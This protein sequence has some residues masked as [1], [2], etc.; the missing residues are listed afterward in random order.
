MG[1]EMSLEMSN[2]TFARSKNG[3]D[4]LKSNLIH[5]IDEVQKNLKGEKYKAIK[6]TTDKYWVGDDKNKF[7][8]DLD[9]KIDKV[10]EELKGLKVKIE[11]I[12]DNDLK[13]FNS[14]QKRNYNAK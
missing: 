12:F 4:N 5:D 7:I 2:A 9:S 11:N 13:N 6:N 10:S 1:L 8:K 14:N 3:N